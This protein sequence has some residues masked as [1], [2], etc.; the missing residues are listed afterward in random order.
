[1]NGGLCAAFTTAVTIGPA[2]ARSSAGAV[3]VRARRRAAALAGHGVLLHEQRAVLVADELVEQPGDLTVAQDRIA[4]LHEIDAAHDRASLPARPVPTR[5]T[6]TARPRTVAAPTAI[7]AVGSSASGNRAAVRATSSTAAQHREGRELQPAGRR[8]A[9]PPR[10][11]PT[12]RG[13]RS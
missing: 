12:P 1:M 3:V 6:T 4:T 10:R 13:P 9:P 8:P 2:P 11:S 5:R 7:A